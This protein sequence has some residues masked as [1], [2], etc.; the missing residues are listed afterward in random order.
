[1]L[2]AEVVY[3]CETVLKTRNATQS[4]PLSS[5]SCVCSKGHLLAAHEVWERRTG[6]CVLRYWLIPPPPPAFIFT[7]QLYSRLRFDAVDAWCLLFYG[8]VTSFF[9]VWK[10]NFLKGHVVM[11]MFIFSCYRLCW[12]CSCKHTV[13]AKW[14]KQ[15]QIRN[16]RIFVFSARMKN[17]FLLTLKEY[18]N[19]SLSQYLIFIGWLFICRIV[20]DFGR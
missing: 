1:M 2:F 6:H 19:N 3:H 8:G 4:A 13:N 15:L 10:I 20:Q 17:R 11:I 9:Y 7:W 18:S 5:P 16:G 12:F 14:D